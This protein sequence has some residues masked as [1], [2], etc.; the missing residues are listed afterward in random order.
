[1]IAKGFVPIPGIRSFA[2]MEI[3]PAG[4]TSGAGALRG[5]SIARDG[6]PS[7]GLTLGEAAQG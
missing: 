1:M 2:I 7:G 6:L 4:V 5:A 3:A